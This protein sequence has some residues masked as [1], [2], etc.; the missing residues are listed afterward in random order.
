M[1]FTLL[2]LAACAPFDDIHVVGDD[3]GSN[4][5]RQNG[6][7]GLLL[8]EV[9]D[10]PTR[11]YK[12]VEICNRSGAAIDLDGVALVRYANGNTEGPAFDLDGSLQPGEAVVVLGTTGAVAFEE[13]HGLL[14]SFTSSVVSGNG[15]DVYELRAGDT[16]VDLFGE[17]GVDGT[18]EPWEYTDRV[19]HRAEDVPRGSTAFDIAEWSIQDGDAGTPFSCGD[20]VPEPEPPEDPPMGTL[21]ITEVMDHPD[22]SSIKYVEICNRSQET[23]S[24]GAVELQ[25][26]SN[27]S[28][29]PA[30]VALPPVLLA[31]G[32]AYLVVNGSGASNFQSMYGFAA[33]FESS[34]ATGNGDDAYA[35]VVNGERL[36]VFGDIGIDGTGQP[37]EYKDRVAVRS[38]SAFLGR[39][40]W[41]ATEWAIGDTSLASPGDCAGEMTI[42]DD[43]D[44]TDPDGDCADGDGDGYGSCI[45]CDDT[46]PQVHPG[47][48]EICDGVDN[49]CDGVR[50]EG[51]EDANFDGVLD[52]EV[53]DEAGLWVPTRN[54]YGQALK[55]YLAS[56]ASNVSCG[57]NSSRRKLFGL[58]DAHDGR[59]ECV[60]TDASA[61]ARW[62]T[63]SGSLN[64]EHTWPQSLGAG[65]WPAKCDM[66]HL[67]PA[68]A[69]ANSA[70]SSHPFGVPTENIT[71]QR[72]GSRLGRRNGEVVFEPPDDHKGNVARALFYMHVTYGLWFPGD[73][74]DRMRAWAELDPVD[75]AEQERTQRIAAEQGPVNPFVACPHLLDRI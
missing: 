5:Y 32:E 69:G 51:D 27:G 10:H 3:P 43:P 62:A 68:D 39:P 25:R 26:F 60:Y 11:G 44:P 50:P 30:A 35:L 23:V 6:T 42:P 55:S 48:M 53:C 67:F 49:D 38:G 17:I 74:Q 8:S 24:L 75:L 28:T 37:W 41:E 71:W 65:S 47:A 14:P 16:T 22:P 46:D 33:D 19:A 15:D 58:I 70:R 9:M 7:V 36:D 34:V 61:P 64:T 63:T 4:G 2:L 13:D 12:Y 59:V 52:C 18:G 45:D 73:Y 21:M 66:H 56:Y 20:P 57:W 40:L 29:D 72:D 1:R 54:L 31:P